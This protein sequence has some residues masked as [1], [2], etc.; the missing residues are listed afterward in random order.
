MKAHSLLLDTHVVIWMSSEPERL[1]AGLTRAIQ[2]ARTRFVSH[3]TAWEIQ[4]KRQ[5]HGTGF[6]FSLNDLER[7]MRAFV[8]TELPI[9]YQ[10][11]R[12]LDEMRFLHADPFD[13]LIMSQAARRPVH[14]ATLDRNILRTFET[15]KAFSL[16]VE[17]L[18]A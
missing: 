12:A 7:T 4:I 15:T 2:N 11:I 18:R 14:L 6:G 5:K 9:E 13:R 8:C 1:P 3:A 16:F 17:E 10:D